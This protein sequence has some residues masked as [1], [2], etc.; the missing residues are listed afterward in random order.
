MA[1]T[2]ESRRLPRRRRYLIRGLL[3]VGFLLAVISIFA[4]WANRQMLDAD[5]WANTSSAL[6][7]NDA[8]RG[9]ISATVVDEVYAKVDVAAEVGNALP[10]RLK[11]LAG[12]AANGLREL[13][14]QRMNKVLGRPRVQQLWESANRVTAQQFINIAEGNSKAITQSGNAVVLDLRPLAVNLTTRLGLPSSTVDKIPADAANVKIMSG[15]QVGFLQDVVNALRGLG[16]VLPALTFVLWGLAIYLSGFRRRETL[17]AVG[18]NLIVAGLLVLVLRRIAGSAVVDSLAKTD[19]A[20]PAA[21]A[22]WSIATAM[23]HEI[24]QAGIVLGIP[25]VFAAWLAGPRRLAVDLRRA[26]A[27]TMRDR[28]G[29][30]YAVVGV[31]VLLVLAWGPIPA[32]RLPIPILLLIILSALGTEVLRRQCVREF[33]DEVPGAASAEMRARV[34]RSMKGRQS[35]RADALERLA[36]LHNEGALTDAEFASEKAALIDGAPLAAP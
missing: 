21:D 36:R 31:L 19:A 6:L 8:I 7:E 24:A 1:T 4:V 9:Q 2:A 26:M 12:P 13:A 16:V 33:P 14:Q 30:A 35:A 11:P 28:P 34:T 10:P 3:A 29:I 17:L 32:T 15:D 25:V 23:L 20:R 18:L 27:P 5:N 22:V